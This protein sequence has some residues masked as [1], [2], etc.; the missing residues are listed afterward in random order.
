MDTLTIVKRE[1]SLG[2]LAIFIYFCMKKVEIHVH[3]KREM[4]ID[5]DNEREII[6]KDKK[7]IPSPKNE[8]NV[9]TKMLSGFN[10][11][12]YIPLGDWEEC[13]TYYTVK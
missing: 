5:S 8:I 13:D 6:E 1:E 3:L 10:V 12:R 7:E 4:Y 2:F 11:G 9:Y